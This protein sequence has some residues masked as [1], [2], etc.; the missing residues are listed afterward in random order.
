MSKL[1]E[2][3]KV[4]STCTSCQ[5]Q[6]SRKSVVF[7]EGPED[8]PLMLV[9]EAPGEHEDI[10]GKPFVGKSG[11]LLTDALRA[12]RVPRNSIFV[13]NILK[14]RT[15]S[16]RFPEGHEPDICVK[17]LLE[18]IKCIQPLVIVLTGKAALKYLLLP[19]TGVQCEVFG[20]FVGKW[21]RR[22][23]KFGE[24][25]FCAIY[26]PAYL[27]RNKNPN[28]EELCVQT[29]ATAWDFVQARKNGTPPPATPLTDLATAPPPVWQSRS[30]FRGDRR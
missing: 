3:R 20:P 25:R 9:G 18:Q 27:I 21:Y 19:G 5:L 2:L 6:D 26:H 28:D 13:T 7:G 8:A 15:P 4:V 12:A 24:T 23:D 16:N 22:R 1:A 11:D 30:L 17:W 29:L 14:C 10:Q